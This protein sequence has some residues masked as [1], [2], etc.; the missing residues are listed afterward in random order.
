M[1]LLV[2]LALMQ[3]FILFY[4]KVTRQQDL[5]GE[6]EIATSAS[7][8]VFYEEDQNEERCTLHMMHAL[9]FLDTMRINYYWISLAVAAATLNL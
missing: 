9:G 5:K 4:T 1:G 6:L 7:Y 8:V 3:L 2:Q